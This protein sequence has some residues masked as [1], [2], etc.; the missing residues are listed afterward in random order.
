MEEQ[1]LKKAKK[2]ISAVKKS[3]VRDYDEVPAEW[4]AQLVQLED[5]YATY[6]QCSDNLR[7]AP[8]PVILIND[9]K[10]SCP[11]F[12]FTICQQ[13]IKSMDKIL[14]GFGLNPV[15][16]KKLKGNVINSDEDDFLDEL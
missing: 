9:G 1:Y 10:T 6:L 15:S 3:I 11:D 2:Y 14:K 16:R 5:M 7:A 13:C 8:S 12:N 4:E